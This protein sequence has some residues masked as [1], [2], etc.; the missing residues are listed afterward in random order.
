MGF[1]TGS[2]VDRAI[3]DSLRR[4]QLVGRRRRTRSRRM[5]RTPIMMM[6]TSILMIMLSNLGL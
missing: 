1:K 6:M 5:M 4:M 2:A 3:A